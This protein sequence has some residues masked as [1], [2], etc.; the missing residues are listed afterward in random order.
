MAV[1]TYDN[2]NHEMTVTTETSV[3][4]VFTVADLQAERDRLQTQ[5]NRLTDHIA[6]V[7]ADMVE[8][9]G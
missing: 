7:D 3:V 8:I 5:V 6:I 9:G 1:I 4:E 2:V